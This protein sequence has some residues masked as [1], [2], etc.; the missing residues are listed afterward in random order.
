MQGLEESGLSGA[1]GSHLVS[2]ADTMD[3]GKAA[4]LWIREAPK[5]LPLVHVGTPFCFV[6]F[7]FASQTELIVN[8]R[9]TKAFS[10]SVTLCYTL[11]F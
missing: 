11:K 10:S 2:C 1:G 5:K 8:I 7:S 9:I 3:R 4:F 6:F